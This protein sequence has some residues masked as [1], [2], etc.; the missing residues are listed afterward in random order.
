VSR[1]R[2]VDMKLGAKRLMVVEQANRV[3]RE[4][5]AAGFRLTLRQLYYQFVARGWLPNQQKEYKR[6]GS[7]VNDARLAGLIDWDAIEDRGRN[8][9]SY[10]FWEEPSDIVQGAA[11]AYR[12]NPWETQDNYVE[13]WVEKEALIGVVERPCSKWRVPHFACKGYTSQSEMFSAGYYRLSKHG[14]AGKNLT[15]LH[16]GDHDPS[17]IDMTRDI[18]DRLALFTGSPVTIKRLALNMDQVE[19]YNPPPNP[20]KL[21]DSRFNGYA[22]LYGDESWELDALDPRV[23]ARL[24]EGEVESLIDRELWDR[25]IAREEGERDTLALLADRYD[26]VREYLEQ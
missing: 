14:R 1:I 8:L 22:D 5:Q 2:F 9:Q 23:I 25:E 13:V 24:V 10:P 19:E 17:G 20:A 15:I 16:F 7:I 26:D 3:I 11:Q 18:D 12:I 4:Y 21:T 6:L